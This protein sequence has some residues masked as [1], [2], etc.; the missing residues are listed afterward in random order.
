MHLK[1]PFLSRG[2]KF[3]NSK[4]GCRVSVFH[5]F[6]VESINGYLASSSFRWLF[7]F[8]QLL[9][10][11]L[12]LIAMLEN[13]SGFDIWWIGLWLLIPSFWYKIWRTTFRNCTR[14][15]SSSGRLVD[16]WR[17]GRKWFSWFKSFASP[18]R[19]LYPYYILTRVLRRTR[20]VS[21]LLMTRVL[22]RVVGYCTPDAAAVTVRGREDI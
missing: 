11:G 4:P 8:F 12:T 16:V 7:F 15:N 5:I 3:S 6:F 14:K 19:S 20:R 13:Q 17:K 9:I 18:H 10:P 1:I 2:L 21:R 22:F